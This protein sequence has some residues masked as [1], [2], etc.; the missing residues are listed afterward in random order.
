MLI[1]KMPLKKNFSIEK[2]SQD[3][4]F[5]FKNDLRDGYTDLEV[6]HDPLDSETEYLDQFKVQH[7]EE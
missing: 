3:R 7:S 1:I 6:V 4:T 5:D 2:F